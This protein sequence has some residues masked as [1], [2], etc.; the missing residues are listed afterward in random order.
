MTELNSPRRRSGGFA[1]TIL[2]TIAIG[3]AISITYG[4]HLIYRPAAFIVAGLFALV[5][6]VLIARRLS[7]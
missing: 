1:E 7:A 5:G 6:A 2:E 4:V 3:G